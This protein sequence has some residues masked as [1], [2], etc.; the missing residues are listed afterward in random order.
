MKKDTI[1]IRAS[2]LGTFADC[3]GRGLA[4][5]LRPLVEEQGYTLNRRGRS[6]SAMV[7]TAAHAG[8]AHDLDAIRRGIQRPKAKD[9]EELAIDTFQGKATAQDAPTI[10]DD[11]TPNQPEGVRQ[12]LAISRL[13]YN[14]IAPMATPVLVEARLWCKI[15]DRVILSGQPDSVDAT[16]VIDDLK[17]G[18][19]S[20]HL[21]Q[22]GGYGLLAESN[23]LDV[24]A[25]RII[26]IPRPRKGR[27]AG[28]YMDRIEG[29][30]LHHGAIPA[31]LDLVE[32][33]TQEV[34][35][36]LAGDPV[37]KVNPASSLCS[38]K[39]CPAHGTP[40]CVATYRR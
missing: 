40:F 35:H 32:S 33:I 11:L 9:V 4:G 6:V 21:L 7:G 5:A 1:N 18:R 17:T 34:D 2:S 28:F 8:V 20:S 10:W 15:G 37:F 27:P 19:R 30:Q 23:D 16:G 29:D 31:V 38:R 24:N 12:L 3:M 26:G 25:A 13:H 39:F 14:Q 22:L 36:V